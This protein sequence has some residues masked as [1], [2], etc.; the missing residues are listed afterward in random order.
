[1]RNY[2]LT[3]AG[4]YDR[5]LIMHLASAN[6]SLRCGTLR[7]RGETPDRHDWRLA[8]LDA[9]RRARAEYGRVH[10]GRLPSSPVSGWAARELST[11]GPLP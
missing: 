5:K 1:M 7:H 3:E 10:Q 6:Y 11:D 4:A 2:C 9:W 8:M